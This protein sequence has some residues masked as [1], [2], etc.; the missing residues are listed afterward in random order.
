MVTMPPSPRPEPHLHRRI[1]ESFGADPERYDQARPSYPDAMIERIVAAS[2]GADF[3]DVSGNGS[4]R[5]GRDGSG[6]GPRSAS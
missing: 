1:A 6:G 5:G 3:L 4:V 2:P